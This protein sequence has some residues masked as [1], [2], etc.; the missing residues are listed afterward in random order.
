MSEKNILA[1]DVG[2]S[3]IKVALVSHAGQVR[4]C[5]RSTLE[6]IYPEAGW[7]EQDPY[8]WWSAISSAA[9]E[10]WSQSSF[11]PAQ[12]SAVVFSCQMFGVLPV[13]SAGKP[14]MNAMIWLDTRSREQAREITSGQPRVAGYGLPR[15]IK[16]LRAT[17]GV[18]SLAG[19]DTISKFIWLRDERPELWEQTDCLLD[20]KDYLVM[21]CTGRATT[22]YD[23]ASGGWLFKTRKGELGWSS[24]I[25]RML[26]LDT[27]RFPEVLPSTEIV[28]D[29]GAE[30]A[31]D[32]GLPAGVPVVAG[33]GDV[34]SCAVGSGAVKDGEVHIY[35][36]TSSWVATHLDDRAVNPFAATGTLCAAEYGKYILIATQETAG[37]SME[38]VRK[39]ILGGETDYD[40]IN[41]LVE[42]CEAGAGGVFFFPWLMGERVPVDDATLRGGFVNLSLDHDRGHLLRAVFEG[43]AYNNL[44]A[45]GVVEKLLRAPVPSVRITGG[46]AQ[47]DIWCQIMAD[48]L[49]KRVERVANPQFCGVRGAALIALRALGE[50]DQLDA[51]SDLVEVTDTFEPNPENRELYASRYRSFLDYYKRNRTWFRSLNGDLAAGDP[52]PGEQP[53]SR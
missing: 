28:G 42:N 29:L 25:L 44:W 26:D 4:D 43:V 16:W 45:L 14:L 7:A 49:D 9:R 17:N 47:S 31:S 11:D 1:I 40:T 20:V 38:W 33:A 50:I 8:A 30:A 13:D 27:K 6:V 12:V 18:P 35:L 34:P 2:T 39:K 53:G 37:A 52:D 3:E 5:A 24:E 19:R 46:G 15:L 10:L 41:R 23:L 51:M 36:G 48:V 22:T 32:L 21:R